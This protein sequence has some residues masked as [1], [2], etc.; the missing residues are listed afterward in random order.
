[1]SITDATTSLGTTWTEQSVV[2]FNAGT[3]ATIS[4]CVTEVE[5]KLR[6][7]TLSSTSSPTLSQVQTW[8]KRAKQELAETKGYTW[9]RRYAK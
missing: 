1:M 6:R 5:S 2:A 9:R 3:L 7:G 4:S 8:L